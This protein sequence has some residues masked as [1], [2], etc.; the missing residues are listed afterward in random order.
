MGKIWP[1]FYDF[2]EKFEK[3]ERAN[4]PATNP[5]RKQKFFHSMLI[6]YLTRYVDAPGGFRR[7]RSRDFNQPT[8]HSRLSFR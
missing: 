2:K 7:P 6:S 4:K 5:A 8:N 3:N 1:Q